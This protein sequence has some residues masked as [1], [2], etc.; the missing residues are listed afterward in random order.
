MTGNNELP[1]LTGVRI[2]CV[3][4]DGKEISSLVDL[5]TGRPILCTKFEL[6][7]EARK[8]PTL[9]LYCMPREVEYVIDGVDA[10]LA[11]GDNAQE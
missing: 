1:L 2:E 7:H 4:R 3:V 10:K 5:G 6:T 9:V 11:E 8:H